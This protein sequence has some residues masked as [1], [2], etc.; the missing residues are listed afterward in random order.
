[1]IDAGQIVLPRDILGAQML[2]HRHRIIGAALDGRVIGD[3]HAFAP[4][5]PPDAGDDAGGMHVAAIEAVGG[6]RRQFEKGRAGI[7]QQIDA[8]ARQ[9]LAASDMARSCVGAPAQGGGGQFFTQGQ[10]C[11][12][13]ALL[14]AWN[15]AERLSIRLSSF[16]IGSVA[17]CSPRCRLT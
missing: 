9:H 12:C 2:L 13:I 14:L 1:M 7:E 4:R 3:D 11:A 10:P 6:E 17:P 5:D 16:A 8:L 15:S